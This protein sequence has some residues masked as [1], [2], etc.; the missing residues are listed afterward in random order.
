[1][2]P[3][4]VG[5][6]ALNALHSA[7]YDLDRKN[8]TVYQDRF[9]SSLG[10]I[11][12]AN[13]VI[14]GAMTDVKGDRGRSPSQQ[15][16]PDLFVRVRRRS[17]E[18]VYISGE[19]VPDRLFEFSLADRDADHAAGGH[20]QG[21]R[22]RQ[23]PPGRRQGITYIYGRQSCDTRSTEGEID[24]GNARFAG[25]Q[26]MIIFEDVFIPSEH[27]LMDGRWSLH[28]LWASALPATTVAAT[29]TKHAS[30]MF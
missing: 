24:A 30:A 12:R 26:A 15:A 1:M 21:L 17:S 9:K 25:Q 22:H 18:G 7:T 3:A 16:D 28:P 14:G 10:R 23:C 5:R 2:L 11:Q 4:C 29:C 20:R 8:G 27:V 13:L 19:G 6:D